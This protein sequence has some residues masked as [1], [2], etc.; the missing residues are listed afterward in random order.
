MNGLNTKVPLFAFLVGVLQYTL[1]GS[2]DLVEALGSFENVLNE[3]PENLN[4]W[5]NSRFVYDKVGDQKNTED[6]EAKLNELMTKA[7]SEREL[8]L[9]LARRFAEQAFAIQSKAGIEDAQERGGTDMDRYL[10]ANSYFQK[11]FD[12][13]RKLSG[14]FSKEKRCHWLYMWGQNHHH[15]YGEYCRDRKNYGAR[16]QVFNKAVDCFTEVIKK[17]SSEN[18]VAKA[19][20]LMGTFFWKHNGGS[21]TMKDTPAIISEYDLTEEFQN[22]GI[23]FVMKHARCCREIGRFL[24]DTPATSH[25]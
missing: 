15:L 5:E 2:G 25:R 3:D 22:P 20:C 17:A 23:C 6:C 14:L 4:A 9:R 13:D 19:W 21:H 1:G 10:H 16:P 11:A 8:N 7:K 24:L 18:Y 12:L